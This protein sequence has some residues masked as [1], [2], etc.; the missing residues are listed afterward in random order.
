MVDSDGDLVLDDHEGWD[1]ADGDGLPNAL[2]LDSDGDGLLDEAEAG[3]RDVETL[4]T[5]TDRDGIQD[6]FDLDSDDNCIPDAVEGQPWHGL[7]W[8]S[9]SSDVPDHI[10]SD[11]D[12]DY[13][14]DV[15]EIGDDCEHPADTDGDGTPDHLDIDSDGDTVDDVFE[16]TLDGD[17]DLLPNFRDLDSDGDGL[18]DELEAGG[19]PSCFGPPDTDADCVPDFRDRDSDN[20]GIEDGDEEP[21]YGTDRLLRDTDGDGATD[22]VE[23]VGGTNPLDSGEWPEEVVWLDYLQTGTLDL[24]VQVDPRRVD[25]A[26]VVD[27]TESMGPALGMVADAVVSVRA[28]LLDVDARV[29]AAAVGDV[30]D[31]IHGLAGDRPFEWV[32]AVTSEVAVVADAVAGLAATGGGDVVDPMLDGLQL[33]LTGSGWDLACD[34]AYDAGIDVPPFLADAADPFGGAAGELFDPDVPGTGVLPGMGFRGGTLPLL[35]F[36]TDAPMRSA[37]LDPLGA[38]PT[39]AG[40]DTVSDAAADRG[41]VLMGVDVSGAGVVVAS[42]TELAMASGSVADVDGDGVA[43][44]LVFEVSPGAGALDPLLSDVARAALAAAGPLGPLDARIEDEMGFVQGVSPASLPA[45]VGSTRV[46]V[47]VELEGAMRGQIADVAFVIEVAFVDDGLV[48]GSDHLVMA[49]PAALA[50]TSCIPR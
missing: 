6:M 38:C 8:N 1:D 50:G 47:T 9:D 44:P 39:D 34:G 18:S 17:H 12:G 28:D 29:A 45:S 23:V 26:F 7:P 42:M 31:G 20:D 25:V 19:A 33:A 22:L 15:D 30:D 36:V 41:A 16:G 43:E 24:E 37:T 2:D 3:D 11:N 49:V 46:P 48:V 10:D 32:S 27:R 4:P 35:V 21:L 5:D 14:L 40:I 13:I